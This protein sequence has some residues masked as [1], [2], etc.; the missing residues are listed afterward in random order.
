MCQQKQQNK[1]V[2]LVRLVGEQHEKIAL[3]RG[4][5]DKGG[6]SYALPLVA[7][8]PDLLSAC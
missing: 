4:K 3:K 8:T 1:M 6:A 2:N 7:L 5:H